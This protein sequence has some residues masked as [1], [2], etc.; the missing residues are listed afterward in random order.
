MIRRHSLKV[1]QT[2]NAHF[3]AQ[4]PTQLASFQTRSFQDEGNISSKALRAWEET[5]DFFFGG[6][7]GRVGLG[8]GVKMGSNRV[9]AVQ[10]CDGLL[11]FT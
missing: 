1:G 4:K 6:K 2:S 3:G 11:M 10:I 7:P 8:L 5:E 9:Q